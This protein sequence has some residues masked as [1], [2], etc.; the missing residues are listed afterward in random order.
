MNLVQFF[1]QSSAS[2]LFQSQSLIIFQYKQEYP[3]LFFSQFFKTIKEKSASFSSIEL[4]A[5]QESAIMSRLTTSFLGG[6]MIYSLQRFEGLDEKSKKMW[7]GFIEQYQGPH[8]L[9]IAVNGEV[10]KAHADQLIIMLDDTIDQKSFIALLPSLASDLVGKKELIAAVFKQSPMIPLDQACLLMHY[11]KVI[12]NNAGFF[13]N[14]WLHKIIIPERSLFSLS[15]FFFAKKAK[16]FLDQWRL[17]S[18]QYSEQF[19]VAYWSEQLWR[20]HYFIE[21]MQAHKMAQAKKISMRLPF[22]FMQRDYKSYQG[23]ELKNAH[24]FMYQLDNAFKNGGSP[25]ALDLFY[26]KFFLGQFKAK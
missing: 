7:L 5:D 23:D 13:L 6:R 11:M 24:D 12:G 1:A 3:L 2:D 15:T 14:E 21:F 9:I 10:R 16:L 19:W 17:L 26:S 18:G 20:A 4:S 8:C 22:T 25:V